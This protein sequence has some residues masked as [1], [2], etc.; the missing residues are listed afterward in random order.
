MKMVF[1]F[2]LK[3]IESLIQFCPTKYH[4]KF[5]HIFLGIYRYQEFGAFYLQTNLFSAKKNHVYLN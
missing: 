1:Y 2:F 3:P 4:W 5:I